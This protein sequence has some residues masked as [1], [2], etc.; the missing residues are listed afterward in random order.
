MDFRYIARIGSRILLFVV[1]I[2][3]IGVMCYHIAAGS[4]DTVESIEVSEGTINSFVRTSAVVVR[5]E[6]VISWETPDVCLFNVENGEKIPSGSTV[7]SLYANSA[8]NREKIDRIA[9]TD[10]SIYILESAQNLESSYSLSSADKQINALRLKLSEYTASG[11]VA[12]CDEISEQLQIMM[13]VKLLKNGY[14]KNFKSEIAS[15]RSERNEIVSSLG[16]AETTVKTGVSGVL[17]TSCDGYE[18]VYGGVNVTSL[19]IDGLRELCSAGPLDAGGGRC[20]LVTDHN[21]YVVAPIERRELENFVSGKRYDVKF[22]DGT[23]N[24]KLVKTVSSNESETAYLILTYD[25][26]PDGFEISRKS[27]VEIIYKK[28]SG[29]MIPVSSLRQ[30]D[31]Y[32]GVYALHGSVVKFRR[33]SVI[34]SDGTYT[35]CDPDFAPTEGAYKSLKFYDRIITKGKDLYDGKIID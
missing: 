15:L 5:S 17:Y 34:E 33:V 8:E 11:D 32:T 21:W 31:G 19:D 9:K 3:V 23:V 27:T 14:K 24:M 10:K 22:S 12:A 29:Y 30:L 1:L 35:V 26:D 25:K 16:E 28:S 20:K 2:S 18:E 13:N 6:R 4:T 7:G